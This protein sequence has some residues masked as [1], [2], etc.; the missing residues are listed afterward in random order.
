MSTTSNVDTDTQEQQM[1]QGI[2]EM[3]M[4]STTLSNP[5]MRIQAG[6]HMWRR[7][8]IMQDYLSSMASQTSPD[9]GAS[10]EAN[11]QLT[12]VVDMEKLS[13]TRRA[14]IERQRQKI[15]RGIRKQDKLNRASKRPRTGAPRKCKMSSAK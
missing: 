11:H 5:M 15:L 12:R 1:L 6:K 10:H 4:L 9:S 14:V 8:Q 13:S 3:E 7:K 2:A